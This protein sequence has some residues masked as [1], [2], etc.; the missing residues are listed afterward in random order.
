MTTRAV[1][2]VLL[3]GSEF[4]AGTCR[5]C[6]LADRPHRLVF[7]RSVKMS[8]SGALSVASSAWQVHWAICDRPMPISTTVMHSNKKVA[9]H[10]TLLNMS[11]A[12]LITMGYFSPSEMSSSLSPTWRCSEPAETGAGLAHCD[13]NK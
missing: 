7:C 4:P 9:M 3:A 11:S 6:V 13:T 10:V 1:C 8:S 12:V 2:C 5:W